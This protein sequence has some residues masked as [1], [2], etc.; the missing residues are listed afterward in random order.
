M[1]TLFKS[2]AGGAGLS[3]ALAIVA[4]LAV[5][6]FFYWLSRTAVPTEV[7][8]EEQREAPPTLEEATVVPLE[9]FAAATADYVGQAVTLEGIEVTQTLGAKKSFWLALPDEANTPYLIHLSPEA[10]A[11][12]LPLAI[13]AAFDVSGFVTAMSDSVLDAWE[14]AGDF[15]Q[16]HDRSLAEFSIDF[17][18]AVRIVEA[19]AAPSG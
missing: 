3:M 17:I 6:G 8:G 4:V 2:R 16:E 18:E 14:A 9:E 1:T 7:A 5:G 15:L 13:G 10:A 12:S 11:D 19:A